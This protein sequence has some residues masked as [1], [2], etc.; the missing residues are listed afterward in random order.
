M[1]RIRFPS[2]YFVLLQICYT[3]ILIGMEFEKF[4]GIVIHGLGLGRQ[5]NFPTANLSLQQ[6]QLS[7]NG[8]YIVAVQH[9]NQIYYG[10]MNIGTRPTTHRSEQSIEIH[11]LNFSQ[12]IYNQQLTVEP[13][14]FLRAEQ[15][16]ANLQ[17]LQSQI[18]KD[19]HQALDFLSQQHININR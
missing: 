14:C 15:K 2:N 12:D 7:P 10:I 4:S 1:T 5:L 17:A 11:L 18:E 9:L 6:G 3:L 13:L 8:V 19:K 16:F